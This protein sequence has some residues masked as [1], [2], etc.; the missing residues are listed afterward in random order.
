M[1][2]YTVSRSR[3]LGAQSRRNRAAFEHVILTTRQVIRDSRRLIE[4]AERARGVRMSSRGDPAKSDG[5]LACPANRRIARNGRRI[6][7]HQD[8]GDVRLGGNPRRSL[9][10]YTNASISSPEHV[11]WPRTDPYEA[12]L[13]SLE[14]GERAADLNRK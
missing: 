7:H 11:I 10:E 3:F 6:D 4:R 1:H 8:I 9:C 5:T 13:R 14:L 2:N 12:L